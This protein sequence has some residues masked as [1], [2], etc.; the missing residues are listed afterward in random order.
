MTPIHSA[1]PLAAAMG[2]SSRGLLSISYE[3]FGL[4]MI[5]S[6][7]GVMW[8][9]K[10]RQSAPVRGGDRR[11]GQVP[12]AASA[13]RTG[14]PIVAPGTP[15]PVVAVIVA[16]AHECMTESEHVVAIHPAGVGWEFHGQGY[17]WSLEGRRD[18]IE[19]RRGV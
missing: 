12:E 17:A 18:I 14:G 13:A 5:L 2:D 10:P 1:L 3:L 19:S 11:R 15:P 6:V 8:L 9:L 16:A 7:L 4:M